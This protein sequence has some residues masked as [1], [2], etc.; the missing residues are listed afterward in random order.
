MRRLI[1]WIKPQTAQ[2]VAA[3]QL[4]AQDQDWLF[5]AFCGCNSKHHWHGDAGS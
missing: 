4:V 5:I 1:G 3:D 2:P